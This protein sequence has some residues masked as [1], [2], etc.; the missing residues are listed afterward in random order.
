MSPYH[1]TRVTRTPQAERRAKPAGISSRKFNL[2]D[3]MIIVAAVAASLALYVAIA[4][5]V[6]GPAPSPPKEL[7]DISPSLERLSRWGHAMVVAQG[8]F[9]YS[10]VFLLCL[11]L[12]F[13]GVRL[14]RPRPRL[15][16]L[17]RSLGVSACFAVLT[18]TAVW[19][20]EACAAGRVWP[21]LFGFNEEEPILPLWAQLIR[22]LSGVGGPCI[23][24]PWIVL[25]L[26]GRLRFRTGWPEIFGL[27]LA[28]AWILLL[29]EGALVAA[30]SRLSGL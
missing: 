30:F 23:V 5:Y 20:L 10:T 15:R 19:A 6:P 26:N 9:L 25:M 17:G 3:A 14:R 18:M 4:A 28:V 11:S 27:G 8:V 7:L 24:A 2:L 13:L 29:A 22:E 1:G 12:A 21:P 16:R